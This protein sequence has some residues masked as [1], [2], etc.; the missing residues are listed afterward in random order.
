MA[1]QVNQT[2]LEG[3]ILWKIIGL[4]QSISQCHR[5]ETVLDY[6]VLHTQRQINKHNKKD[7]MCGPGLD[8]GLDKIAATKD[9]FGSVGNFKYG[10][11]SGYNFWNYKVEFICWRRQI[12]EYVHD[13]L[14][15]RTAYI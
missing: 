6:K 15:L 14:I 4:V 3:G 13:Y 2:N 11:G 7:A 12:A 8:A 5:Q 9:I 1:L 10:L